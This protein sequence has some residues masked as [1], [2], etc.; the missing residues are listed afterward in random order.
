VSV[1]TRATGITVSDVVDRLG[2]VEVTDEPFGNPWKGSR[3]HNMW[4]G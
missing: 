4:S 3:E 2:G 1:K